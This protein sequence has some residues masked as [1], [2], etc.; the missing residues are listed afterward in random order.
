MLIVNGKRHDDGQMGFAGPWFQTV[1]LFHLRVRVPMMFVRIT[2]HRAQPARQNTN[3][4]FPTSSL[5]AGRSPKERQSYGLGRK[6]RTPS[7]S[8]FEKPKFAFEQWITC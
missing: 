6:A 5:L 2:D 1:G 7:Q 4:V 3:T 8:S